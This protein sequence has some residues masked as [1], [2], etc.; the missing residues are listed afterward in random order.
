[1]I[2]SLM[3][4]TLFVPILFAFFY[5]ICVQAKELMQEQKLEM[6]WSA[7]VITARQELITAEELS[8]QDGLCR[9]RNTA[10]EWVR[11]RLLHQRLLREVA[12][13]KGSWQG[14]VT[15]LLA[16]NQAKVHCTDGRLSIYIQM[17]GRDFQLTIQPRKRY[18]E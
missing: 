10:G 17:K 3:L 4:M 5:T 16:V 7:F 11:Y 1:M 18:N 8:I 14:S 12:D 9:W 15:M 2:L 13:Q 6:Q